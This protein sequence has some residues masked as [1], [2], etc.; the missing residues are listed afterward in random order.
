MDLYKRYLDL[1]FCNA[2]FLP[3][4]ISAIQ[5][6]VVHLAPISLKY[7]IIFLKRLSMKVWTWKVFDCS[8]CCRASAFFCY[9]IIFPVLLCL[10]L[11]KS[12][13]IKFNRKPVRIF[14]VGQNWWVWIYLQSRLHSAWLNINLIIHAI[15]DVH[16]YKINKLALITIIWTH[17]IIM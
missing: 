12:L 6:L 10:P 15:T 9:E 7:I 8:D 1:S 17:F 14:K 5:N 3:V 2:R 16:I 11:L 4:W 13:I